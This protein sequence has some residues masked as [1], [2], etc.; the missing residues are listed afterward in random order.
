MPFHASTRA[1]VGPSIT[2]IEKEREGA[3]DAQSAPE[4]E[5]TLML[6]Q[7]SRKARSVMQHSIYF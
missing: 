5:E 4:E 2:S 1:H 7:G 6:M 3:A